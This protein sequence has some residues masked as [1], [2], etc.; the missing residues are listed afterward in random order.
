MGVRYHCAECE[1][2]DSTDLCESCVAWESHVHSRDHKLEAIK[3]QQSAPAGFRDDDYGWSSGGDQ[4]VSNY[5]DPNY[6]IS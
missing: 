1:A 6:L 2:D 4:D 5:L 3:V